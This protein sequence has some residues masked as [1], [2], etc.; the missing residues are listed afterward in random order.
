M[1]DEKTRV[2]VLFGGRSAEHEVSVDS[3]RSVLTAL[4]PARYTVIPVAITPQGR[5]LPADSSRQLLAARTAGGDGAVARGQTAPPEATAPT[6][7]TASN[8]L[9]EATAGLRDADV[10]IPLV[11]GTYGE[12]GTLQG[13]LEF[14]GVPYVGAGVAA[15]AVG[16]DK[17]LMRT[18]LRA[19]GLPVLD[20]LLIERHARQRD[21]T[22]TN[23]L[24]QARI[25]FPCF[26][27]PSNMGSS[28]G[29]HKVRSAD[30]LGA[31]LDDADRY[32]TRVLVERAAPTPREIEC[33]VL[34]NH[35][36][37]VSVPGEVVPK[38]DFYDYRAK[39]LEDSSE[40]R[41]PAPLT[42]EQT[43]TARQLA[44]TAFRLL[45]CAGMARVDMFL[46]GETF[47]VNEINTIPGFTRISMYPKLWEASGMPYGQVLDRLIALAVERH[48][49]RSGLVT[50]YQSPL[51][52]TE[53]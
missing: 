11:H 12:D 53:G 13:V 43:A 18:V 27:K 48:R 4:D 22:A 40:L 29:V 42:P 2:V 44:L 50:R 46:C 16:M 7:A 15:S 33:S 23:R 26:V 20:W 21:P 47:W 39:Y 41:I 30:E 34:G 45:D 35:E 10:V 17:H 32:D 6:L 8:Q 3:A 25:G 38:R 19:G 49:E 9:P 36:P 52:P 24:V 28:V 14:A 31:A 5:W 37:I 51:S 1:S